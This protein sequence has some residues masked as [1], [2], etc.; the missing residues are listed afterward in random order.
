MVAPPPDLLV[1]PTTAEEAESWVRLAVDWIGPAFHPDESFDS[2]TTVRID[3][4]QPNL[5]PQ[6]VERLDDALQAAKQLLEGWIYDLAYRTAAHY[7]SRRFGEWHIW[8]R[9]ASQPSAR[10]W[11][12]EQ[13][14]FPD[15]PSSV[16]YEDDRGIWWEYDPTTGRLHEAPW[17][18]A[19]YYYHSRG[20]EYRFTPLPASEVRQRL[21]HVGVW[22]NDDLL[23]ARRRDKDWLPLEE[24]LG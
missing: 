11:F 9:P 19:D 18:F 15:A 14:G 3:G 8:A 7:L 21:T 16:A 22:D 17:L 23:G 6:A 10:W 1:A 20:P 12:V 5:N 4:E 2:Y 13:P 24:A